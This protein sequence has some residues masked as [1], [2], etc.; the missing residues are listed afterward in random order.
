[1]SF[2]DY[3][4][5]HF[6]S[7]LR[8]FPDA[9]IV[10]D[11]LSKAWMQYEATRDPG[12][13]N[14]SY[15]ETIAARDFAQ[16]RR[17]P[18]TPFGGGIAPGGDAS[19]SVDALAQVSDHRRDASSILAASELSEKLQQV[20]REWDLEQGPKLLEF[21]LLQQAEQGVSVS[22][23]ARELGVNR[24]TLYL[25]RMQLEA[26]I[27]A[28]AK[29]HLGVTP[30]SVLVLGDPLFTG[31]LHASSGKLVLQDGELLGWISIEA[32]LEQSARLTAARWIA[33]VGRGPEQAPLVS[34]PFELSHPKR[35]AEKLEF[36]LR[37]P[38][39]GF[40]R[41]EGVPAASLLLLAVEHRPSIK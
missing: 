2:D 9:D 32:N 34:R 31:K 15:A 40:A 7:L 39:T 11:A 38:L 17:D 6:E 4:A 35:E 21:L 12:K 10:N 29:S 18:E 13:L 1:M 3:H 36:E 26:K 30:P 22:E 14:R 33:L 16:H 37:V 19:P 24:K 23:F 20:A 27:K 41:P 28:D 5:K 8:Q 25:W